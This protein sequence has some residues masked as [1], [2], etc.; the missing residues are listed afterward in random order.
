MGRIRQHLRSNVVGYIALFFA[1]STGSAVALG[2][3]DTV[4]SDDLGPGAQVKAPDVAANAVLS[5]DIVDNQVQSADVRDDTLSQGG[6]QATDL[7]PNSVGGSEVI[8]GSL[9]P[10]DS[11]TVV[12]RARGSSSVST[13]NGG[14]VAYPLSNNTWTQA[15]NESDFFFFQ[16]S[17]DAPTTCAG[18]TLDVRILVDGELVVAGS[19]QDNPQIPGLSNTQHWFA[20]DRSLLFEPGSADPRTLTATIEDSCGPGESFTVTSL[21]VN[22]IGFR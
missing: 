11:K 17:F 7:A 21:K 9:S 3:T 18:G 2:G 16:I 14:P 12:G 1:L 22:V 10:A 13:G 5:D 4:Q 8:N 15:A 6:L 19:F 20:Y